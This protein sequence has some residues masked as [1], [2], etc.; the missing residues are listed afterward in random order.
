MVDENVNT[1][2]FSDVAGCEEAKEE[3]SELVDFLRDL[4]NSKNWEEES[5]GAF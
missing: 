1:V 3:V 5:R 4:A 2:N